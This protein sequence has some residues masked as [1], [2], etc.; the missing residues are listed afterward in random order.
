MRVVGVGEPDPAPSARKEH[1]EV[2]LI[3]LRNLGECLLETELYLV[4]QSPDHLAKLRARRLH[5]GQLVDQES[6]PLV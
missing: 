4:L 5:I 2:T 6:V 3:C 1:G